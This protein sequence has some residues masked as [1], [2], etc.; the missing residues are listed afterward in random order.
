MGLIPVL[1]GISVLI[2]TITRIVPADPA[3]LMLGERAT[4]EARAQLRQQMGLD[5]PLFI[6]LAAVRETAN[7]L[8]L[9]DSQYFHFVGGML[10]GDLGQS[11]FTRS[12]VLQSLLQRFPATIELTLAAMLFA[13]VLGV[14]AGVIAALRRGKAVDTIVLFVAL[15]GVSLPVFWLAIILINLFA[16]SLGWLP[17]TGR[18][19]LILSLDFEPVTGLYVFDALLQGK[20]RVALSALEHLVL[21]GITLGTIPMAVVVRM[22]RSAMLDALGQDYVRTAEAKGLAARRVVSK[23]ALRN[24]LPPVVTVVGL[25][26]GSLLSG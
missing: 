18:L 7:P 14:P 25:S 2:F 9:F 1:L 26:F 24:A 15:S 22:T 6:N 5:E 20:P 8:A 12:D 11:Y 19:D 17:S 10:R 13:V 3:L 4:P 16:V 23:H 21:P